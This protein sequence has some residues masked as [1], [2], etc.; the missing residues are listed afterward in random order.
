MKAVL[1]DFDGVIV[2]STPVHLAGWAAAY[3]E[4]FKVRLQGDTLSNLVGRSTAA[5]GTLLAQQ[6]GYAT[7]KREL[8]LRKVEYVMSHLPDIPLI[9]GAHEFLAALRL[10]K[11]PYGIV[12]NAPRDFIGAAVEKHRLEVPFYLGLEDYHRPKP[13]AEPY[14]KGAAKLGWSFAE[15]ASIYVFE[16]S[17]HGIDAALAAQMTPIGICSQHPAEILIRAGAQRCFLNLLEAKEL[18]SDRS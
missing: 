13:D 9:E 18:I 8:I 14:M 4:M 15:H 5:I 6:S 2:D 16:D 10:R 11:I 12:S 7:A 1:F 3:H 17:T